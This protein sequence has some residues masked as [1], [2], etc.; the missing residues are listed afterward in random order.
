MPRTYLDT[1]VLIEAA[2]GKTPTSE[3]ALR[4]LEDPNRLFLSSPLLRLELVPQTIRNQRN[5]Q[6]EFYEAYLAASESA[7]D[8]ESIIEVAYDEACRSPVAGLDAMHVAAA[9]LLK[10]DEF[11]TT[12]KPG[13]P[14]YTNTL[15]P[16]V[17]FYR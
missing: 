11:V 13:K 12:E 16:V 6:T 4:I 9:S 14:L 7:D 5:D 8:L 2:R 3:R 1:G 10:A 15:V 17:Y